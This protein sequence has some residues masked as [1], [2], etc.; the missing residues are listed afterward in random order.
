MDWERSRKY[1][2]HSRINHQSYK[3]VLL[4]ICS[5]FHS[6]Y[7]ITRVRLVCAVYSESFTLCAEYPVSAWGRHSRIHV[8][9][10]TL[11]TNKIRYAKSAHSHKHMYKSL[12]R[13]INLTDLTVFRFNI[14]MCLGDF[15]ENILTA[16]EY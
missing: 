12:G 1:S 3:L 15:D 8:Q 7:I 6:W 16:L 13:N 14:E 4:C 11:N 2:Y 5:F 10:E 9:R